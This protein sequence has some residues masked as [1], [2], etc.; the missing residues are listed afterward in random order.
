[1]LK[2]STQCIKRGWNR[3]HPH[4]SHVEQHVH[5]IA[6]FTL[7]RFLQSLLEYTVYIYTD[8]LNPLYSDGFPHT[9]WYNKYG[10]GLPILYSKGSQVELSILGCIFITELF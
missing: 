7:W 6:M 5:T 3:R 8:C 2:D 10:M 9:Y 1:M 4:Q